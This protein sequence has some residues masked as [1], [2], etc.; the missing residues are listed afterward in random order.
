MQTK[1]ATSGSEQG[2]R[3]RYPSDMTDAEWGVIADYLASKAG[4]GAP[5]AVNTRAVMDAIWYRLR[6]GCQW[7]MLP[8]DFP[9]WPTVYYYFRQWGDDGTLERINAALRRQVRGEAGRDPEPSAGIIDSQTIKT[10]EA[11]GER[12]FDGGKKSARAQTAYRG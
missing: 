11:G 2:R 7:R 4:P 6:T 10:T 9:A 1:N 3:P 8:A 5:R 12:G